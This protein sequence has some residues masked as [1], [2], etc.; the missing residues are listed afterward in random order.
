VFLGT[1]L[2]AEKSVEVG[3]LSAFRLF[4]HMFL[5]TQ[6]GYARRNVSFFVG[7][8]F[9]LLLALNLN[10]DALSDRPLVDEMLFS[11]LAELLNSR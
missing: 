4:L 9:I 1:L 2:P 6:G 11:A 8:S 3:L 5:L 10:H 7:M